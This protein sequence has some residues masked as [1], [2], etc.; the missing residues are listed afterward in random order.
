MFNQNTRL[1]YIHMYIHIYKTKT[2]L[3]GQKSVTFSLVIPLSKGKFL[4]LFRPNPPYYSVFQTSQN[5]NL[6]FL[7]TFFIVIVIEVSYHQQ[8]NLLT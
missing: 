8:L 1:H 6:I 7:N 3:H 4:F 2:K 5:Y